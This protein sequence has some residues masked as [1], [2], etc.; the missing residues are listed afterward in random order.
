MLHRAQESE[1]HQNQK[2]DF[3]SGFI[4]MDAQCKRIGIKRAA[5]LCYPKASSLRTTLEL[6]ML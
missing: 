1:V 2:Y 6:E 3:F 4:K 5:L